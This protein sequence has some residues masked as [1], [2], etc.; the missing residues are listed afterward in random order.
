[1]SNEDILEK[2]R[3]SYFKHGYDNLIGV[4]LK[5]GVNTYME[6]LRQ[7]RDLMFAPTVSPT[8]F[9]R[10]ITID[11]EVKDGWGWGRPNQ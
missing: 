2:I 1:M 9:N 6:L 5:I 10:P 8:I 4:E 11:Y 3:E 7:N